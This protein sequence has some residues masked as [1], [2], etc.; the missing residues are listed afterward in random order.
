MDG[1]SVGPFS[2]VI[3]EQMKTNRTVTSKSHFWPEHTNVNMVPVTV[4]YLMLNFYLS[5]G[6]TIQ[7]T[8]ISAMG[9]LV[10]HHHKSGRTEPL[11]GENCQWFSITWPNKSSP[12][13]CPSLHLIILFLSPRLKPLPQWPSS[14]P[15]SLSPPLEMLFL[16]N[17]PMTLFLFSLNRLW[18]NIQN[19]LSGRQSIPSS[20][21]HSFKPRLR[22]QQI[23]TQSHEV[24]QWCQ[25][26]RWR[27]E[28]SLWQ[29]GKEK[30]LKLFE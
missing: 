6:R 23:C 30:V 8:E 7:Q 15:F 20:N 1:C 9:Y 16:S 13:A 17:L 28:V 11:I 22:L 24:Q 12:N 14:Y 2:D 21:S 19:N 27:R 26:N 3:Q 18:V 29:P 5:H 25:K 4:L 10:P